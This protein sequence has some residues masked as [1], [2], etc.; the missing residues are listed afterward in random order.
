MLFGEFVQ[1]FAIGE[2]VF[3]LVQ[4]RD[5]PVPVMVV[6]DG[7]SRW[8]ARVVPLCPG[9]TDLPRKFASLDGG[10]T[11]MWLCSSGDVNSTLTVMTSNV[12]NN[13]GADGGD[14]LE[15]A[16]LV[17]LGGVYRWAL[18]STACARRD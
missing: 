16:S 18:G 1:M 14:P 4:V 5:S 15:A 9:Q 17:T 10:E 7:I 12:T 3:I 6:F 11:L 2:R 13:I 8:S